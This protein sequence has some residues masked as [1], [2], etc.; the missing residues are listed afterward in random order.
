MPTPDLYAQL[1]VG[2]V[3]LAQPKLVLGNHVRLTVVFK[4]R[5]SRAGYSVT[6]P[7][8]TL[9][10]PATT[11]HPSPDPLVFALADMT[12]DGDGRWYVDVTPGWTGLWG[13]TGSCTAPSAALASLALAVVPNPYAALLT[14]GIPIPAQALIDPV[15]KDALAAEA[16]TRAAADA[17]VL[18]ELGVVAARLKAGSIPSTTTISGSTITASFTWLG[19]AASR[20]TTISGSTITEVWSAPWS[21]TVTTTISGSTI[22]ITIN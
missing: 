11:A 15:N 1:L 20:V 5:A 13:V 21:R 7:V 22:S 8:I 9:Q 4:D 18:A 12:A 3:A 2:G 14:P 16:A 17:A 6:D 19:N 10:P